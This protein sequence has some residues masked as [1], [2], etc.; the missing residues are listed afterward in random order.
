MS[1]INL[2]I[3]YNPEPYQSNNKAYAEQMEKKYRKKISCHGSLDND[4]LP[5][6]NYSSFNP[7]PKTIFFH[8]T[9][10]KGS[11]SLRQ[12]CCI[13]SAAR[14]HPEWQ[15]FV[16]FNSPVSLKALNS[17]ILRNLLEIPN[18]QVLR[19]APYEYSIDTVLYSILANQLL[20]SP[21]PVEHT[22]DLMRIITLNKY[23][24]VYLDLDQL[25]VKPFDDLP[26]NWIAK[27]TKYELGSGAMAF[28][29]DEIGKNITDAVMM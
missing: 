20:R 6:L 5:T 21:Y 29:R 7:D 24:G 15:V 1:Y 16:F 25:V 10:C 2:V 27:E 17:S 23:G 18:I 8:E 19:I 12:G 28:R 14:L 3:T 22:A 9:S 13:E 11:L 4:G 26:Q